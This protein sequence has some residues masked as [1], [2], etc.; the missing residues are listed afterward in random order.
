MKLRT[1]LEKLKAIHTAPGSIE[2][3]LFDLE[4]GTA[5]GP[6]GRRYTA[7]EAERRQANSDLVIDLRRQP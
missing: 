6:D 3:W 1:R 7:Q 2:V 4:D 5:T